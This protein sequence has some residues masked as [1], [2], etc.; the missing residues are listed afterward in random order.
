M[1]HVP[2]YAKRH[3]TRASILDAALAEA[4]ERG[5]HRASVTGIAARANT[6]VGNLHYH[7]GSRAELLRATMRKLVSDFFARLAAFEEQPAQHGG[8]F[9]E[10]HRTGLL[11]Y[12]DYVRSNP[13]HIRLVDEIRFLEPELY[14]QGIDAW[15]ELISAR[16]RD[17]IAAGSV[18]AMNDVEIAAQAHFLV[19]AHRFLE[20]L[21]TDAGREAEVV[22]AYLRLVR[23]GLAAEPQ[24]TQDSGEVDHE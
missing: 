8:D 17:G 21:V 12:V 14:R 4:S 22:D 5:L 15:V 2:G 6:A 11:A 18:R 20:D 19:G 3:R 1:A 13:G 16:L 10:R 23:R 24:D 7:F 9:F